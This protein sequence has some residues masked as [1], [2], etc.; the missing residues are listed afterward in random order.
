MRSLLSAFSIST[1]PGHQRGADYTSEMAISLGYFCKTDLECMKSDNNSRCVNGICDCIARQTRLE[2]SCSARNTGCHKGTFQVR[3][4]KIRAAICSAAGA[5]NVV[6][7][8]N[9][10]AKVPDCV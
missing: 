9:Y 6:V 5:E 8:V 7:L 4:K 3:K 10:S 1:D 2:N